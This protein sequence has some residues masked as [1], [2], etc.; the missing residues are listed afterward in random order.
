M[1]PPINGEITQLATIV[2]TLPQS[3]IPQPPAAIPA[4]STPPTMEWV[5]ETGSPW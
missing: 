2:P 3:A 5:V 4:P 1:T